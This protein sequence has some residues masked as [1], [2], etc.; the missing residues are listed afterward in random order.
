LPEDLLRP[1]AEVRREEQRSRDA[2]NRVLAAYQAREA[3]VVERSKH[4][5]HAGLLFE[6]ELRE[7]LFP[8]TEADQ[9]AVH[10]IRR[11]LKLPDDDFDARRQKK[12]LDDRVRKLASSLAA[13]FG[14]LDCKIATDQT[15]HLTAR[16]TD[17]ALSVLIQTQFGK[18]AKFG[19]GASESFRSY[20]I[21]AEARVPALNKADGA[22]R[23]LRML[24]MVAGILGVP[25]GFV[26]LVYTI[27]KA[28]GLEMFHRLW[29]HETG[30]TL[31]L[32]WEPG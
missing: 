14:R 31:A 21:R 12:C 23:R 19:G 20:A 25:G 24:C 18:N 17:K 27:A 11:T 13:R 26:W 4:I 32:P 15:G 28:L 10:E 30:V 6:D 9:W 8:D 16:L 22:A 29:L 3:E 7:A 5:T 1:L 2:I